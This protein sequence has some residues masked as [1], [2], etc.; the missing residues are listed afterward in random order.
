MA[1]EEDEDEGETDVQ[2]VHFCR[3]RLRIE[4]Q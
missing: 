3:F 1:G 4:V 2:D